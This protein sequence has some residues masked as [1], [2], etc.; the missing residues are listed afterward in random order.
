[1]DRLKAEA[2]RELSDLEA[3]ANTKPLTKDDL[4]KVVP[5]FDHTAP[6]TVV[7]T[8]TR[9]DCKG[10]QLQLSVKGDDGITKVLLVPDSSQFLTMGDTGTLSCGIQKPRRVQVELVPIP[11]GAGLDTRISPAPNLQRPNGRIRRVVKS[12]GLKGSRMRY[13]FQGGCPPCRCILK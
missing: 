4:A 8:L 7:G 9:V 3:R 1:M 10:K 13:P 11:S 5:F 2:R 12:Q 6:A